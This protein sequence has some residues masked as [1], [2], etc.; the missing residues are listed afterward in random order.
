MSA[1]ATMKKLVEIGLPAKWLVP[2]ME[3]F[4][5]PESAG[6][7]KRR[8]RRTK[9]EMARDAAKTKKAKSRKKKAPV[10]A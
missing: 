7:R 8:K 2:V 5:N 1:L 4:E 10:A 9:E 3:A 6:P